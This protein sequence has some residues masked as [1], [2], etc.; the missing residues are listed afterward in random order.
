MF[1]LLRRVRPVAIIGNTV[2]V[3]QAGDIRDVLDRF[4]DF[5]LGEVLRPGIP[6]GPFL[7]TVDWR[8]QHARERQLLQRVV[9]P[10]EDMRDL[11]VLAAKQCRAQLRALRHRH[12]GRRSVDVVSELS[13][14]VMVAVADKYFGIPP[15]GSDEEKMARTMGDIA[16]LIMVNPSEGSRRW[17]QQRASIVELSTHIANLIQARPSVPGPASAGDLLGRLVQLLN[18]AEP[19]WFDKDWVRRHVIGLAG[20]GTATVVRATTHAVDR[21]MARPAAL[22]RAQAQAARLDADEQASASLLTEAPTRSKR[23]PLERER[24]SPSFACVRAFMKPFAF[25]RCCHCLFAI[26]RARP[27]LPRHEA[28]APRPRG[29]QGPE[30][31]WRRCSTRRQ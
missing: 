13:A 22:R 19:P 8:E 30:R 12:D 5:L 1:A 20:T 21:L 3:T 28:R 7:M 23:K 31:L 18:Q 16:S 9:R 11:K 17:R 26:A 6:W 14:P 10:A 29:Q 4:D 27:S 25:V 24:S 2:I 15:I